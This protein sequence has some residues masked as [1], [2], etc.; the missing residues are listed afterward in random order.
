MTH[1]IDTSQPTHHWHTHWQ[2]SQHITDKPAST[3]LTQAIQHT[4]DKPANTLLTHTTDTSQPAHTSDTSQ[5]THY[6]HTPLTSKPTHQG[7]TPLTQ[8][9]PECGHSI[10]SAFIRMR[11]QLVTIMQL[12]QFLLKR[13]FERINKDKS[14]LLLKMKKFTTKGP[15]NGKLPVSLSTLLWCKT[16]LLWFTL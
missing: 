14:V 6:W 1:T 4:T 5:P 16:C 9:S 12:G 11:T 2:A 7:H 13:H 15:C 8:A 3:P 10:L